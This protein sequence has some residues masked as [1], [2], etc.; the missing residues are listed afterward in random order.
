MIADGVQKVEVATHILL[1]EVCRRLD[2]VP[3]IYTRFSASSGDELGCSLFA[4]SQEASNHTPSL[5]LHLLSPARRNSNIFWLVTYMARIPES[6]CCHILVRV[7]G[8]ST[9]SSNAVPKQELKYD[10]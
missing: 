8:E 9:S 4:M 3:L 10:T 7:R 1:Q 6:Q 2:I 5:S